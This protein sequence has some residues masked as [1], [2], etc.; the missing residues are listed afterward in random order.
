M[1]D[2]RLRTLKDRIFNPISRLVPRSITP[3]VITGL[4]FVCGLACCVCAAHGHTFEAEV[5]W[6]LNRGLD[7]LDGAVAR[8]R[9]LASEL[10]GFLDLLGDFTI[11]SLIPICC[12]LSKDI[13]QRQSYT[14]WISVAVVEASFHLNN[15]ILFYVAAVVEKQKAASKSTPSQRESVV[16]NRKRTLEGRIELTSV[17][18]KATLIEGTESAILFTIM[19]ARPDWLEHICWWM[20]ALVG[21]GIADRTFYTTMALRDQAT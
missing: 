1:F 12:G 19:L 15:F 21:I 17:T 18:M 9:N 7:C 4:A 6:F 3:L 13:N 16:R 8:Q 20:A 5:F 11:Y 2:S 14:L 10:G